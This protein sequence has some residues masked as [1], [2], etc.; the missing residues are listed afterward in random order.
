MTHQSKLI[1]SQITDDGSGYGRSY[2]GVGHTTPYG[3]S[4]NTTVIRQ[5]IEEEGDE[6]NHHCD[7]A[8]GTV[9]KSMDA[10]NANNKRPLKQIADD[11]TLESIEIREVS[12]A[13]GKQDINNI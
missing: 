9:R 4:R 2:P 3:G 12:E 11:C 5:Q 10:L 8:E 1:R 7:F 13:D 6:V